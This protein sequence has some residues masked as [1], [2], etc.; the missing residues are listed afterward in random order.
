MIAHP[1]FLRFPLL[2]ST[3][4]ASKAAFAISIATSHVCDLRVVSAAIVVPSSVPNIWTQGCRHTGGGHTHSAGTL[5]LSSQ[6]RP[7]PPGVWPS[8]YIPPRER[9][10]FIERANRG[11]REAVLE[12]HTITQTML[13]TQK[14]RAAPTTAYARCSPRFGPR[15]TYPPIYFPRVYVTERS[16]MIH[17]RR[18]AGRD[19]QARENGPFPPTG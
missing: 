18:L 8:G 16:R 5:G 15:Q 1:E 12:L 9:T 14:Q 19:E 2:P 13:K 10:I 3:G 11:F 7:L 6:L 17:F 4:T